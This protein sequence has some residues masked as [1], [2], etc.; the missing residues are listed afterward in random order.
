MQIVLNNDLKSLKENY[1]CKYF[2]DEKGNLIFISVNAKPIKDGKIEYSALCYDFIN[3]LEEHN[4]EVEVVY[5]PK[6]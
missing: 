1:E 4:K 5:N 6:E 3:F 2:K